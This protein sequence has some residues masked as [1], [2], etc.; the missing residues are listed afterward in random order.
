VPCRSS[1]A[2]RTSTLIPNHLIILQ[3]LRHLHHRLPTPLLRR[4]AFLSLPITLS[5]SRRPQF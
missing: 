1:R 2:L 5:T 3:H 4:N